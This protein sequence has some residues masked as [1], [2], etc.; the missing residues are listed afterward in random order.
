MK[1]DKQGI[2][3]RQIAAA[4]AMGLSELRAKF[5]ELYGFET[6]SINVPCVRRRV[7]YKLQEIHLGGL[8]PDEEALL[9]KYADNDRLAN[10]A[11]EPARRRSTGVGVVYVR[12]WHGQRHEVVCRGKD[13]YE[14]AGTIY[15]SLS[16]VA[17]AV[18]GTKWNG[19]AFFGVK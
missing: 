9:E 6:D 10:L 13:Q 19:R 4:R 17:K 16:A 5:L 8:E 15:K 2:L 14:Y 3:K 11:D 18:T 12:E 7:I 1:T